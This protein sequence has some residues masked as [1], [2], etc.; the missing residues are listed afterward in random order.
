MV[1]S[2]LLP[3]Q[4]DLFQDDIY[5]PCVSTEPAL[6]MDEWVAGK[7]AEPNRMNMETLYVGG[8]AAPA[9]KKSSK[10][11]RAQPKADGG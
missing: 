6:S 9:A 4:S 5:P 8:T 11:G 7:N 3:L 2:C 1:V 10:L